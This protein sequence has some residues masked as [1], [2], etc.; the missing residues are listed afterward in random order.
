MIIVLEAFLFEIYNDQGSNSREPK[1][2][3]AHR[4]IFHSPKYEES[5][6]DSQQPSHR[7]DLQYRRQWDYNW[8]IHS[9]DEVKEMEKNGN[10]RSYQRSL[11]CSASI[12][13]IE[14]ED[15][16]LRKFLHCMKKSKVAVE[17]KT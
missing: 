7:N 1:T 4:D 13:G 12:W 8:N 2:K 3:T 10:N 17:Q 14:L 9:P 11:I 15:L 16:I 5:Q 6:S